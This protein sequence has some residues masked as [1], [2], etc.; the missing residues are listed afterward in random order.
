MT[1]SRE[2]ALEYIKK[3][4]P[5]LRLADWDITLELVDTPWRKSGDIK[6][7][8]ANKMAVLMLNTHPVATNTEEVVIH[9]LLHLRLWAMDQMI[10]SLINLVYGQQEDDPKRS[11]AY[12]CF[13][14]TLETT[15]ED[16]TKGYLALDGED[17][18]PGRGRLVEQV[19][20]EKGL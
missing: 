5:L 9:E 8:T 2:R 15:V 3:W 14:E 12:D 16:L 11:F 20:R 18:V 1:V 6:I 4:Q 17:P 7:D 10:E 13:M 19:K